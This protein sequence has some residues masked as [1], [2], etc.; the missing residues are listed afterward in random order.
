MLNGHSTPSMVT[1]HKSPREPPG[2]FL[3]VKRCTLEDV[4]L[5][6]A[7]IIVPNRTN[8]VSFYEIVIFQGLIIAIIIIPPFSP[9]IYG[10]ITRP[11]R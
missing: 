10:D 11:V 4:I 7:S 9:Y 5:P 3:S 8:T 2:A 6:G 1:P